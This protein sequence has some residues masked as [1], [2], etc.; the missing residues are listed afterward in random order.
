MKKIAQK[1]NLTK[2]SK[3][4]SEEISSNTAE[5]KSTS[6]DKMAPNDIPKQYKAAVITGQQKPLEIQD[7]PIPELKDGEVLIKTLA[8]GVCHS[9]HHVLNGDMGPPYAPSLPQEQYCQANNAPAKS[10]A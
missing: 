8:C 7:L 10:N 3:E 1:L 4:E 6:E 2:D 5:A 9:D